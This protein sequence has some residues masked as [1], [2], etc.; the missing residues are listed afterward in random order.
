M[1]LWF[2]GREIARFATEQPE[3]PTWGAIEAELSLDDNCRVGVEWENLGGLLASKPRLEKILAKAE[4]GEYP[5]WRE[6][7]DEYRALSE[8]YPA[9]KL[10]YAWSLLGK[11]YPR[12][13][14][15]E[16]PE[17]GTSPSR[18]GVLAAFQDLE[19]LSASVAEGVFTSRAKDWSN[20]FRKSTYRSEAEMTAVL[21]RP[22]EN[23]FV[24]KTHK[25]AEALCHDLKRLADGL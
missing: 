13:P 20:P 6:F 2:A 7:H 10:R 23:S 18:E 12:T 9:D 15:K 24:L 8:I 25:E 16:E 1:L 11:L 17:A 4:A 22:A 14:G 19:T 3:A 5:T 21:G